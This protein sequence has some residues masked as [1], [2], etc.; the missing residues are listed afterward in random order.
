MSTNEVRTVRIPEE[1]GELLEARRGSKSASA[2]ITKIF[3]WYLSGTL[4]VTKPRN[5]KT[6]ISVDGDLWQAV[7]EKVAREGVST[8]LVISAGIRALKKSARK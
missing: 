4:V 6:S 5:R 3:Q 7:L 8:T 2:I 1:D